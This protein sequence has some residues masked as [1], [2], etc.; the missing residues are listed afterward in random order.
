MR[1]LLR[2]MAAVLLSFGLALFAVAVEGQKYTL[3]YKFHPG[4]SIRWEVEHRSMV[5]ITV[6]RSTQNMETLSSSVSVWRVGKVLPDGTATFE[7]RVEWVDM[8][9]K[10]T[11]RSEV[12]YDSRTDKKPPT[13][14]EDA[15]KSVGVSLSVVKMDVRGKVL[16]RKDRKKKGQA[17]AASP[18][19]VAAN[20]NWITIPLPD[21]PVAVG[22]TWSLPQ[23]IDVP[24]PNGAIKKI[25]AVQRFVLEGVKTG[26][27]TIRVSTDI[28]T[29]IM[30]P[31]V[32][33]QLVQREAKGRVRFD[34]DAGR[35]LGQQM[36]I[37]KHVV[38]V[39]G[40]ASS[41]HYVN[42]FSERLLPEPGKR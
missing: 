37:D 16:Q 8:R 4:E 7:H 1:N 27:A 41:L 18:E 12:H 10:L 35:I 32:E 24:L 23:E 39:R 17:A 34:I 28:I 30:D 38:G 3:R 31:A 25:K 14:F 22:H 6:S 20:D 19:A 11:G 42:S 5:R 26:V 29:S 9:H 40:D 13:G 15:A 2:G 21:E 36:D 33:S